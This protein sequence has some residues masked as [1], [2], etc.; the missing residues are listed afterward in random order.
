V[1]GADTLR[2]ARALDLAARAHANQ[3]RK[4]AAQEP[5]V[6]HLVEVAGLVAE[7]TDGADV[8]LL[9]GA[10]LHDVIEDTAVAFDELE[11]D[12]GGR[13][14]GWVAE[15]SDDMSVA[16]PERKRRRLEQAPHK[17]TGARI[18]KTADMISNL[19]ATAKSPPAG[20]P[21]EWCLGYIKGCRELHAA[22]RGAD[23]A[24]DRRF[25][26]EADRA[27]ASV[28][29]YFGRLAT[30]GTVDFQ[31]DAGAGQRVHLLYLPNT[32][33]DAATPLDR[34]RL[35][36]VMA[37]RFSSF[38]IMD[39]EGVF[40]GRWRPVLVVRVRSDS[41]DAVV[42]TAQEFCVAFAQRFVGI[43]TEGRYL[44]VYADDTG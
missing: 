44:R 28:E 6:N 14:A 25:D 20:W 35:V 41:T 33:G 23:D 12:F 37:A 3:R 8:D 27:A 36:A 18:I 43:E 39:G 10:L 11:R 29:A 4:G 30:G 7:A 22:M 13:V 31:L 16:K 34:D 38:T 15:N 1:S 17:S 42:A 26:A 40:E 5:Y 9:I 2:L 32:E 24:L 19:R 21:A